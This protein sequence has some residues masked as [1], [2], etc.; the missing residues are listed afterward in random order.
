MRVDVPVLVRD[1]TLADV[2][3]VGAVH[4]QAWQAGYRDL[5]EP[6]WLEVF[7]EQRRTQWQDRIVSPEF[8]KSTLLVAV[9]KDRVAAFAH[10]G[11]HRVHPADAEIYDCYAD[12]SVWGSGVA[13]VLLDSAWDQLVDSGYRSVR[14]WTLAGANRARRFYQRFG[15]RESGQTRE[16]DFGDGR[17]VLEIEYLRT[18]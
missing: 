5:F 15:F 17:P 18:V 11:Q 12:P 14:L 9:R 6:R 3:A 1:A 13:Y 16:R 2:A 7:V 10:F 8:A 4:A